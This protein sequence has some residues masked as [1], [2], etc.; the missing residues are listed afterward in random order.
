MRSKFWQ[1][2]C[3]AVQRMGRRRFSRAFAAGIAASPPTLSHRAKTIS[4][5]TQ[6]ISDGHGTSGVNVS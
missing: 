5:A 4:P 3:E 6:A 2:I 1:K